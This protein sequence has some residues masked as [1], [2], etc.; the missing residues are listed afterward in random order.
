MLSNTALVVMTQPGQKLLPERKA[1]PNSVHSPQHS[2]IAM[3]SALVKIKWVGEM[4]RRPGDMCDSD[5]GDRDGDGSTLLLWTFKGEIVGGRYSR[6]EAMYRSSAWPQLPQC[7]S[8]A[9]S[10]V[11]AERHGAVVW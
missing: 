5:G 4:S 6:L 2:S 1:G 10:E 8:V 9:S 7:N 3:V 11:D